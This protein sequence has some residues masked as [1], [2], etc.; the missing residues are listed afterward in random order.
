[1][2][3]QCW[4]VLYTVYTVDS[5]SQA[6]NVSEFFVGQ[7]IVTETL[8][9]IAGLSQFQPGKLDKNFTNIF[10]TD[11]QETQ[12]LS[13]T[14]DEHLELSMFSYEVEEKNNKVNLFSYFIFHTLNVLWLIFYKKK[15]KKC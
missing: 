5:L 1:M 10:Q 15:F 11:G 2:P 14:L 12:G 9:F 4:V 8:L 6:R 3:F 13:H 7:I